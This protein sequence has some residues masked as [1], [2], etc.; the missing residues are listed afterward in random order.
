MANNNSIRNVSAS[1]SINAASTPKI[2]NT[3][4]PVAP[5]TE[6]SQ[7]LT[8]GTKKFLLRSRSRS[9]IKLSFTATESGTKYLTIPAGTSL[10]LEGMEITGATLY[11][12]VAVSSAIIE[13]LE[14]T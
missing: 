9:T 1:V 3:T 12:Q 6:F 14:W 8:N 13:I 5:N 10:F 11:M 2:Y 7:A 4:S